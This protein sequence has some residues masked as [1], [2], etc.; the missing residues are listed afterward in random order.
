MYSFR[1]IVALRTFV[2]LRSEL[3]LQRIRTAMG[4]LQDYDLTDHP[5]SYK[6]VT[7]R[8][9]I[10]LVDEDGRD[11][12]D[13]VKRRGQTLLL[14]MADV[15]EPFTNLQGQDVVD[16]RQ[17]RTNIEVRER[18]MGGWPTI[19]GTRVRY[20]TVAL[21]LED[22]SV[23]PEDAHHYYPHVSAQAA[24]DAADFEASVRERR[25]GH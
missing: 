10:F 18:R 3:P 11:L 1:D 19:A 23:A 5:S 22:G 25:L 24:L 16:F 17:P 14:S 7:D 4:T 21:L 12:V 8:K 13:L 9:T 15:F 2:R 20:D 6:L